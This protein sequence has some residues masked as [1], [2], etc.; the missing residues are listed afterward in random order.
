[1]DGEHAGNKP[2]VLKDVHK[3]FT[4]DYVGSCVEEAQTIRQKVV[5]PLEKQLYNDIFVGCTDPLH[6]V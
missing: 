2:Y 3:V 5:K 1:M 4:Q 6:Q